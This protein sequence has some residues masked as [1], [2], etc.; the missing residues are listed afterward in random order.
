VT[1]L[2]DEELRPQLEASQFMLLTALERKPGCTQATLARIFGFDKTTVS[3]NL[4][5][6]ERKGWI[7]QIIGDDRRERGLHLTAEGRKLVMAGQTGWGRAQ[8][9]LRSAMTAEQWDAMW[10]GLR[11][12][13]GAVTTAQGPL[14]PGKG[15]S[16]P[17]PAAS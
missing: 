2:Y 11:I 1:Q 9:R 3:R 6:L 17:T 8:N 16:K 5:V 10:Q 14:A 7:E 15:S 12:M 4:G 13:T